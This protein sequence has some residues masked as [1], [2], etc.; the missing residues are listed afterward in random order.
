[1]K[2][3]FGTFAI[4]ILVGWCCAPG[5]SPAPHSVRWFSDRPVMR[6]MMVASCRGSQ[7]RGTDLDCINADLASSYLQSK[8]EHR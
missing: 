1:M 3:F 2:A 5:I 8:S 6:S 4:L 7:G